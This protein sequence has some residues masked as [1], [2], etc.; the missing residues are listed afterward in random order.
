MLFLIFGATLSAIASLAHIGCIIFGAKWYIF[1]GAGKQMA[2]W[3]D[4]KNAKHIL[5]TLPIVIVLA[6]W[7]AYAL[8]GAAIIMPLPLLKWALIAITSAY[9]IRGVYGFYFMLNPHGENSSKFWFYSSIICLG[10]GLVHLM[11]LVQ[12]WQNI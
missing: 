6:I 3:A 7:S 4:E 1:F 11:G 5:I 2:A 10:F 8:S 12:M 9:L